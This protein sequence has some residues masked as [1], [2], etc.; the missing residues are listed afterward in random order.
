MMHYTVKQLADLAGVS[1]RTLHVYDRKGLLKPLAR[2][3]ARYRLYG[4][5]ELL[6][7][8]QILFYKELDFPLKEI[9]AMLDDPEFDLVQALKAHKTALN[10][11]R[12]R[13]GTL[14]NTIDNTIEHLKNE[15]VMEK[16]EDL[17]QGLPKEFGTTYRDEA[18][19]EYGA[20][21]VEKSESYLLSQGKEGFEKLKQ[22]QQ[23][24]SQKLFT[25]RNEDPRG[26]VVQ[27]EVAHHYEIIRQFWGT[28]GSD[29]KQAEAYAGLGELYV[30]DER[31]TQVNG[32]PQPE[33]AR[34]LREAM[35]HFAD[36]RLK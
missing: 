30:N 29:D 25:L 10:V 12:E 3:E 35:K 32:V 26:E 16:P 34:F 1:V 17:Y 36:T 28:F 9:K 20:E 8:Q 23:E 18:I 6:R 22:A 24:N 4:P 5:A 2:T 27:Q 19:E 31:F 11:R 14:L 7:L 33:Y 15:T 21:S 13:I